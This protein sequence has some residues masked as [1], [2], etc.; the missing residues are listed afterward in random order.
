MSSCGRT[1]EQ[2]SV[3][4]PPELRI[5][6]AGLAVTLVALTVAVVA[7]AVESVMQVELLR[8]GTYS[9]LA[10]SIVVGVVTYFGVRVLR[11][12]AAVRA[13]LMEVRELLRKVYGQGDPLA[14]EAEAALR[15]IGIKLLPGGRVGGN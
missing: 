1:R 6:H 12:L 2:P 10:A 4:D 13:P 9:I 8:K 15:R 7:L 5:E 14:P 11:E 3:E